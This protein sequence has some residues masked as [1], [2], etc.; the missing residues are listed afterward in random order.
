MVKNVRDSIYIYYCCL[1][2]VRCSLSRF[3]VKVYPTSIS[4]MTPVKIHEI[5][6][7]YVAHYMVARIQK[8][9]K[10]LMHLPNGISSIMLLGIFY[11][12]H[13]WVNTCHRSAKET[14]LFVA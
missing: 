4:K 7:E 3:S 5:T 9:R 10:C 2:L 12:L 1:I 6:F 14:E 8:K 13:V 11:F